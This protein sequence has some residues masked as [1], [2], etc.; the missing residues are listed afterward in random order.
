M[1]HERFRLWSWAKKDATM[2]RCPGQTVRNLA[3]RILVGLFLV[4]ICVPNVVV[5]FGTSGSGTEQTEKRKAAPFPRLE[6]R[7]CGFAYLPKNR[8]IE[9]FPRKFEAYFNDHFGLR[10]PL[11]RAYSLAK[12]SGLT[13]ATLDNPVLTEHPSVPVIV[14]RHGWLYYSWSR[15]RSG[16]RANVP[17][18]PDELESWKRVLLE[19]RDWLA[20]RGV[21]YLIA[22]PPEKQTIYPE[23]MPR[24]LQSAGQI[25]RLDQLIESLKG[26]P[27]IEIVDMRDALRR[28]KSQYIAY[29]QTDTHWNDFGAFVGYRELINGLKRYFPEARPA[30]LE[31]YD[32]SVGEPKFVPDLQVMLDAPVRLKDVGVHLTPHKPQRAVIE[33]SQDPDVPWVV[34]NSDGE[35]PSSLVLFDSFFNSMMPYFNEHWQQVRYVPDRQF[36]SEIIDAERPAV[37]V[38][39]MVE[40]HL[41]ID[42]PENPEEVV[43]EMSRRRG[44][45]TQVAEMDEPIER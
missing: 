7:W 38:Q 40:R 13:P 42:T 27:N 20:E 18:E 44:Q 21:R 5:W 15:K 14:G 8:S 3:N 2:E 30:S 35:L 11:I 32:V 23:F 1:D 9:A 33:R 41:M 16:N 12:L 10:R 4:G 29:Y 24:S 34:R 45:P 43:A 36:P 6:Y 25:S 17:F 37:V 31:A 22:I 26:E 19:R 28:A 39:E